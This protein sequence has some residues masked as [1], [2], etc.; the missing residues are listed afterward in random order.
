[1]TDLEKIN[2]IAC[3]VDARFVTVHYGILAL[4]VKVQR[5]AEN[6][7]SVLV[8]TW[9]RMA[10]EAGDLLRGVADAVLKLEL[11]GNKVVDTWRER[12][13]RSSCRSRKLTRRAE[14]PSVPQ[15]LQFLGP[16]QSPKVQEIM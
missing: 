4:L 15:A 7:R 14:G 3:F 10:V 6:V 11:N 13:A 16:G 8:A 1:M 5:M 12:R 9:K 2:L